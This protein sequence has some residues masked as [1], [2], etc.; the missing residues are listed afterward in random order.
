MKISMKLI[1]P[2]ISA[3]VLGLCGLC[4]AATPEETADGNIQEKR[5][6]SAG[7]TRRNDQLVYYVP[8]ASACFS[9]VNY[10]RYDDHLVYAGEGTG[11]WAMKYNRKLY[12]ILKAITDK[13][14]ADYYAES[15]AKLN[16]ALVA[17]FDK[18][19][20]D[21]VE[22]NLG[23]QKQDASIIDE[24]L[25]VKSEFARIERNNFYDSAKLRA[26]YSN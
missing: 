17:G 26:A 10:T 22:A 2:A 3:L 24:I 5:T 16:R 6:E 23:L 15:V 1:I 11:D 14:S 13:N 18:I 12:P 20:E 25:K 4:T 8:A 9:R 7:D 21:R 19:R